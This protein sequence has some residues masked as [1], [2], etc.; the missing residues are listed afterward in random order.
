MLEAHG[1]NVLLLTISRKSYVRTGQL[2]PYARD[3]TRKRL[4]AGGFSFLGLHVISR[5]HQIVDRFVLRIRTHTGVRSPLC[6]K[7][8][9]L[10]RITPVGFHPRAPSCSVST[11]KQQPT[12][13][14]RL[15]QPPLQL[16][17]TVPTS[18][19]KIVPRRRIHSS[20]AS[21]V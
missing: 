10:I 18:S 20:N 11:A 21:L 9:Q 4:A 8:R 14:V 13:D 16:I 19:R 5:S 2:H 12:H 7:T 17:S 3:L 15:S 6:K 1:S